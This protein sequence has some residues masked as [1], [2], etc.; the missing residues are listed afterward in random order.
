MTHEPLVDQAAAEAEMQEL[1]AAKQAEIDALKA[2]NAE[3]LAAQEGTPCKHK[4]H[5]DTGGV[6]SCIHCYESF[7][8]QQQ[9]IAKARGDL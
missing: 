8:E 3:L 4:F 5:V 2:Q 9:A 6:L 1:M 7:S